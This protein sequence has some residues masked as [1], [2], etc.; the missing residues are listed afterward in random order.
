M[1][2]IEGSAWQYTWF[3]PHDVAGLI[4]LMGKVEFNNRLE[5]GFVKSRQS[6]F[7]ATGDLFAHY[8]INHGNQP[9]MQ[10]AYLFNYSGQPW[11]TQN[12][13]REIMDKYYGDNPLD[14]WPG[15]E[16]QGQMGAWFV[17]SAIG[18]FQMDGG[19]SVK[20]VYEI[21]SPLFCKITIHLDK[22]YY[23]GKTFVIE[24]KD[25]SATNRYIQSAA[26]DGKSLSK[27]WF[28]H[29]DLIDGGSLVLEMGPKP[30]RS[31]ATT[32]GDAP[33]SMSGLSE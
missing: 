32:P 25:C 10:A 2:F 17:M 5:Q 29:S 31:W 4:K 26:L 19:G 22:R 1:G 23:P 13:A 12:W 8:P 33:P 3:V 14:G 18:L 11:K 30:N 27:C 24:A 15:D 9:N 21:G 6:N 20:P 7:N 16:D 28:Y